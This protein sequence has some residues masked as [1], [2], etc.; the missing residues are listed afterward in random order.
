MHSESDPPNSSEVKR[1]P[2]IYRT[3]CWLVVPVG[4]AFRTS[5]IVACL[6]I[7]W[8]ICGL[9]FGWESLN[10]SRQFGFLLLCYNIIGAVVRVA[11][12]KWF[13]ATVIRSNHRNRALTVIL[14]ICVAIAYAGV[15][16]FILVVIHRPLLDRYATHLYYD[17]PMPNAPLV[18][19][20]IGWVYFREVNVTPGGIY[21]KFPAADT[22][23]K[24]TE[25]RPEFM[26]S[27][28]GNWY[29]VYDSWDWGWTPRARG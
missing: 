15:L 25:D 14:L 19:Q 9:P 17:I 28:G 12:R 22:I 10:F 3:M 7:L 4:K 2:A 1:G 21:C 5:S 23:L 27:L 24:W 8:G 6:A 13:P 29:I 18:D 11:V 20:R 26:R 16:P